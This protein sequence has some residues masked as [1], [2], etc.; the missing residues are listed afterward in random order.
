VG[1]GE[2]GMTRPAAQT[3]VG[4]TL[5]AAI[6]QSFPKHQRIVDDALAARILPFGMRLFASVMST[7]PG[8]R[9]MISATERRVP[10]IWGGIAGRKRYIDDRLIEAAGLVDAVVNLGAGLDTRA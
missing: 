5:M 7:A 2:M 3:G 8:R 1:V 6:E 4:P 10:G 9:W